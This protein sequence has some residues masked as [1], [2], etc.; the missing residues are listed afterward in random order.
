MAKPDPPKDQVHPQATNDGAIAQ[1]LVT[2][3]PTDL[4]LAELARLRVRYRGFP[5]ARTVQANLDE[6]LKNWGLTEEDLFEKT[7]AIHHIGNLYEVRG[8]S[9]RNEEDWS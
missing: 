8:R 5:G 3:P 6:A 1:S 7:R 2:Q 9:K 4:N